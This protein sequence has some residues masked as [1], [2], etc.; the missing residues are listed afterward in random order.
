MAKILS[1]TEVGAA[2]RAEM[3]DETARLKGEHN[4]VPGLA[5]VLVGDNPASISY[6][7]G[8]QKACDEYHRHDGGSY[9]HP[10]PLSSVHSVH[11]C[12][13]SSNLTHSCHPS[14]KPCKGCTTKL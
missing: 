7:K 8:K 4:V 1:G 12:R 13:C 10:S 11:I 5:V 3:K 2:M 14:S 9:G 6:V